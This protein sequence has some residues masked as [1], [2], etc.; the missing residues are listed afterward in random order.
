M[1]LNSAFLHLA[2]VAVREGEAVRRG[3]P[4]GTVGSTGRATGPHL[5]WSLMWNGARID[6]QAVAGAMD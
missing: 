3:Q 6:P 2:T 1:G 4:I 5:H